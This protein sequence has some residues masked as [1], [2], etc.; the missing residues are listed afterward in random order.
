ML[1][2]QYCSCNHQHKRQQP[3]TNNKQ[4]K[5]NLIKQ[6]RSKPVFSTMCQPLQKTRTRSQ[7][8]KTNMR[9]KSQQDF[10]FPPQSLLRACHSSPSQAIKNQLIIKN[11][12]KREFEDVM[13]NCM[14]CLHSFNRIKDFKEDKREDATNN[15]SANRDHCKDISGDGDSSS[16]VNRLICH[17]KACF[18]LNKPNVVFG[19]GD[20]GAGE[21]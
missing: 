5:H 18:L 6:F 9:H 8:R 11:K 12:N 17:L 1:I 20:F 14:N 7:M 10:F 2:R 19:E 21:S 13:L 15:E 16:C 3:T 4:N